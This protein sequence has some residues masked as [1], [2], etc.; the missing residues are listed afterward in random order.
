[1][2]AFA[3]GLLAGS[4]GLATAGALPDGAQE[5]AHR[6]LGAVGLK[7]PHG[8]QPGFRT[9]SS[10][11]ST[12]SACFERR[13]SGRGFCTASTGSRAIVTTG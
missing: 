8:D 10:R 9:T 7:V 12:F 1:V 5:V 11:T 3:V 6:T 13:S 4:S 2:A